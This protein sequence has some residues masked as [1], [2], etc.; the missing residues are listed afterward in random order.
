MTFVSNWKVLDTEGMDGVF[1]PLQDADRDKL[2]AMIDEVI[3][4]FY[5]AGGEV[6]SEP[7]WYLERNEATHA[8]VY[9]TIPD[10][11]PGVDYSDDSTWWDMG[12]LMAKEVDGQWFIWSDDVYD[13]GNI[14]YQSTYTKAQAYAV[15]DHHVSYAQMGLLY[16]DS[17]YESCK[18]DIMTF[19]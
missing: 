3:E 8:F 19:W 5:K 1:V 16:D 2:A 12:S 18:S 11:E 14:W 17:V 13:T 7:E 9:V 15:R 10:G 4:E 6:M